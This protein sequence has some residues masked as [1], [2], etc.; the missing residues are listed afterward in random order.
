MTTEIRKLMNLVENFSEIS[1]GRWVDYTLDEAEH[2]RDL[3]HRDAG[4]QVSIGEPKPGLAESY[5]FYSITGSKSKPG[6]RSIVAADPDE[7]YGYQKIDYEIK[8]LLLFNDKDQMMAEHW[9]SL[10]DST[11]RQAAENAVEVDAHEQDVSD[12]DFDPRY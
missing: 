1:F 6:T 4:Y 7:Y 11:V 12:S 10:S 2:V 5:A 9:G 8:Y 3:L